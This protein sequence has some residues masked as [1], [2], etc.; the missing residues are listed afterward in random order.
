MTASRPLGS[1]RTTLYLPTFLS[2]AKLNKRKVSGFGEFIVS[3]SSIVIMIFIASQMTNWGIRHSSISPI[4]I[5][6]S[7]RRRQLP[8]L[9][10]VV[11]SH[12]CDV[13]G[14]NMKDI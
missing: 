6:N 9:S 7:L 14:R 11:I 3:T 13:I 5:V 1:F 2:S 10:E 4:D 12:G 8:L